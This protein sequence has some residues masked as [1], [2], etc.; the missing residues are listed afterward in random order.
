M[1]Q[2]DQFDQTLIEER[3]RQFRNQTQR[4]LEGKLES[5]EFQQLRLRNGLYLQKL[6]PMLRVAIPY[7]MLSSNQLRKLAHI[8]RKYD[9]GYGHFTTRQNIQFNWPKLEQVPDILEQLTSVQMHAIQ[10]SGSCIRNITADPLAGVANDELE[11]PRPWA[12]IIRQWSTLHPEFNWL[13]RKFKI[14]LSGSD[15]DRAAIKVHDI[16]LRLVRQQH[17]TGFEVWVGG[18]LGRT[19]II[20]SKIKPFLEKEHLLTYLTAIL[21]V[22]NRLGRRDNKYKARIKILVKALGANAF[23]QQVESEWL[24]LKDSPDTISQTNID[25]FINC[26]SKPDYLDLVDESFSNDD[27]PE[28]DCQL[29]LKHNVLDHKIPG[30]AIVNI[31]LKDIG[32][33]P[34]DISAAQMDLIAD[35]ADT[36]SSGEIRV[37]HEQNLVLAD[38]RQSDLITLWHR[39]T[40]AKL[41]TA[42]LGLISD[43]ICCPGGD[44][45]SL[46]NA[47]SIPLAHAIQSQYQQIQ[48]IVDIGA[49]DIN[50]SGCMNACGHHHVGNIGILGVDKKGLEYYQISVGGDAGEQTQLARILGPAFPE[51]DTAQAIQRLVQCY[52]Q[53]RLP[54]ES[55][56]QTFNRIGIE[57][58]KTAAYPGTAA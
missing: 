6:A 40:T 24:T 34:G 28:P 41:A 58:F 48:E 55:F 30:Y 11:D 12:E 20:A 37:T 45:C 22:Y 23:S 29:W 18:G 3:T 19:P 25:R 14:A 54:Q 33:A 26:F 17:R 51:Q 32:S 10:T 2:Y 43:V 15:H 56:I 42:N 4:F 13:P 38:V 9:K 35:L 49:L 5:E 44:F 1:Y 27:I 31:A 46:A 50:I 57:P 47:K 39:L 52:K 16:G 7:G 36:Y 21:R 53:S 8:S